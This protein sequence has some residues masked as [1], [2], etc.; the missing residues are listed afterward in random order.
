MTSERTGTTKKRNIK[1]EL[2]SLFRTKKKKSDS[3]WK[4]RFVCLSNV[5]QTR[6]PTTDEEKDILLK[7]DLGEK[8]VLFE[9]LEMDSTEFREVLYEMFPKLREGGGFQFFKCGANSRL[10]EPL[11]VTTLSSPKLLKS[12]V[13]YSRTYIKPLQKNLSLTPVVSL[14]E[15]VSYPFDKLILLHVFFSPRNIV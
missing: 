3:A 10:L 14:P 7:A 6:I 1:D 11:S 15:G 12:C 9:R 4:H 8:E 13:G 2:S 5:Q